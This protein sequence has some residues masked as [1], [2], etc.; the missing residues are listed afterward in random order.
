M[1]KKAF[2]L[3]EVLIVCTC[4]TILAGIT[5]IAI[6]RTKINNQESAA[7]NHL[8]IIYGAM[9]AYATINGGVYPT[10]SSNNT[11]EI[12]NMLRA[13]NFPLLNGDYAIVNSGNSTGGYEFCYAAG[14]GTG[15]ESNIGFTLYAFP[16]TCNESG[17]KTFFVLSSVIDS[18]GQTDCTNLSFPKTLCGSGKSSACNSNGI[19]DNGETGVD[20]GGGGCS[21]CSAGC[22]P[23]LFNFNGTEFIMASDI[24][25]SSIIG[26]LQI[27]GMPKIQNDPDEYL[28]I[29]NLKPNKDGLLELKILQS[30]PEALYLDQAKLVMVDHPADF[31]ILPNERV[32][33]IKPFPEFKI[34][35]I[36][37]PTPP[38]K[39]TDK[40]GADILPFIKERDGI[41]MPIKKAKLSGFA[42]PYSFI[43]D[44]GDLSQA[45]QIQLLVNGY[46]TYPKIIGFKEI[47]K[48][49]RLKPLLPAIEV[50]DKD[51][52]W[53]PILDKNTKNPIMLVLGDYVSKVLTFDLTDAFPAKDYRI[54]VTSDMEMY[55]DYFAVNT[56]SDYQS[57]VNISD[58]TVKEANLDFKGTLKMG[59]LKLKGTLPYYD[60]YAPRN[61]KIPKYNP[62]GN[63]TRYGKITELLTDIDDKFAI[64]TSGDEISLTFDSNSLPPVQDGY[65]RDF[66][67]YA[68]GYHK[69]YNPTD[70]VS[71][72]VAPLPFKAMS[73][74][75]Y[76][77]NELYPEDSD[78]L[79][80]Q[81]EYNTRQV[82]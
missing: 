60:Y 65:K 66:L 82:N 26:H 11:Q 57:P 19:Q 38:V 40:N 9:K 16:T 56:F 76:P 4:I 35:R 41:F 13:G 37:N 29:E 73:G 72:K 7:K 36:K 31:D 74:Y 58:M 52:N 15:T 59:E 68:Y 5:L 28:K 30:Y 54:R 20:C 80:Y 48:S 21:A 71:N 8:Q 25:P 79:N 22:C 53:V 42:E 43:L 70:P 32:A 61:T 14:T 2:S 23:I 78:H 1:N 64:I 33:I 6:K 27:P 81:K 34:F 39:A 63:Y 17:T 3:V 67:F 44:L 47:L 62:K 75:P 12:F 45:K 49:G 18:I 46:T 10:S 50:P 55:F 69:I 24:I 77:K 51:G